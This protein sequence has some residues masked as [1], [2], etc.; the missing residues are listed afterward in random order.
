M[1]FQALLQF[2]KVLFW[3]KKARPAPLASHFLARITGELLHPP[4]E[5]HHQLAFHQKSRDTQV[6]EKRKIWTPFL[7]KAQEHP[8]LLAKQ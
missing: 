7:R 4:V 1:R 2:L 3:G 8:P 5:V 6:I